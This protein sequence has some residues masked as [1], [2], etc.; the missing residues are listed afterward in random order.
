[1]GERIQDKGGGWEWMG[2]G[3]GSIQKVNG[4]KREENRKER[5][6]TIQKGVGQGRKER[7]RERK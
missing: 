3:E 5:E 2:D 7:R 1:M 4:G 6:K